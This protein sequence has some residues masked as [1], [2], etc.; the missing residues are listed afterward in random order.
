[1]IAFSCP[2]CGGSVRYDLSSGAV[3]CEYCGGLIT[4]DDY[5]G[6]LDKKGLYQTY[7][8]SCPQC[9]AVVLSYDNTLATFCSYCGSSVLFDRRV[10]EE[11]KPEGM[12]PFS[13]QK[14]AALNRYRE[15][16]D[17][18]VLAPEWMR[19]EGRKEMTGIYMPFYMYQASCAQPVSLKGQKSRVIGSQ[20]E[21]SVYEV[22]GTL[23]ATYQG[24]RVD[25]AV[26]F[27]DALSETVDTYEWRRA[28]PFR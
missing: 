4:Q 21:V 2:H 14:Q 9:G 3:R 5:E 16:T 25:A 11:Q 28:E 1:M 27:P 17:K 24:Q 6:Y 26:A 7:E 10:K 22:D 12:I 18:I 23:R 19:E 13:F 8:L 20:T 15:R